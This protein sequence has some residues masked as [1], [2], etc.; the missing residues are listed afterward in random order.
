MSFRNS[1]GARLMMSFAGVIAVFGV[2]VGVSIGGLATF[3]S[4]VS[5]ITGPEFAKVETAHSWFASLSDSMRQKRNMILM[6]DKTQLQ[7]EIVRAREIIAKRDEYRDSLTTAIQSPEGKALLHAVSDATAILVPKDEDFL[8][9]LEAG[10]A[11]AAADILQ[12]SISPA[13]QGVVTALKQLVDYEKSQIHNRA[14]GLAASY[15]S[16][17][18]LLTGLSLAAVAVACVLAV[19]LTRAFKNPLSH[20]VAVLGEI[21]KGNYANKVIVTSS[22]EIGQT[23]QGLQ[24]MQVALRVRTEKEQASATEKARIAAA[25][26]RVSVGAMLG[27][28]EGKIIYMNEA[29]RTLLRNRAAEIRKE[30]PSFDPEQLLG[31]SFDVFHQIHS[32]QRNR[33]AALTTTDT[34]DVKIGAASLRIVANPVNDGGQRVGTVV[35]WFDRT[36]EVATEEEVQATVARAIDGDL[37][38]RISEESKEGFFKALA[39]GMNRLLSNMT[40]VVRNMI[41][42]ADQ[43]RTAAGEISRGNANLSRRTDEQASSLEETASSMDEMT[44]TVKNNA[45]NAAQANQLATAAKE[46]AERGG[47][48]V[49]AAVA[50]MGEINASSKKIAE[51]ISVIDEIAFQT[52]LLALNAA[53]E[54]ARAGEQGRGFA[55]V[56]S[57]VRNLAS[58]S[59]ESA[60]KIKALINDSVAKITEGAKLVDDSGKVLGEIVSQVKKVTEVVA[61]IAGSTRELATGIKQVN[62]TITMMDDATQQNAALVEEGTAAAQALA[63]QAAHLT[64]L[65]AGYRVGD[66]PAQDAPGPTAR[67][68]TAAAPTP[69]VEQRAANR[70]LTGKRRAIA[71]PSG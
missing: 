28:G 12:R 58:R 6:V 54:A 50:A 4:A 64:Q 57:E 52:N 60:K 13:N 32:L 20:A 68:T 42:A 69:L 25:L 1:V 35:Q 5:E 24:R 56:A 44:S 30:V 59:A 61:E 48:V 47:A 62:K 33:L 17:L 3:N 34:S 37:I 41:R 46:Q 53:V 23:L 9:H 36:Q 70:P 16:T 21:E 55:V 29:V 8:R 27:D 67:S 51:I 43:V 14:G 66:G 39:G 31:S 63:Q 40:D 22:D 65:I 15:Q 49:S 10:D 71:L 19:L 18:M 45:D 2:A 38:A 11:T 7:A 26:D